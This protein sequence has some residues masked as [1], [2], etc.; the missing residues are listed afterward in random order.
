MPCYFLHLDSLDVLGFNQYNINTTVTF[1]RVSRSG[2]VLEIT[3]HTIDDVCPPCYGLLPE[4]ECCPQCEKLIH[5]A[6]AQGVQPAPENWSQCTSPVRPTFD[7]LSNDK[8]LLKGKVSVN[9]VRGNFHIAPG[10][11]VKATSVHTHDLMRRIPKFDLTH[12]IQRLR[13]GTKIPTVKYG[14]EGTKFRMRRSGPSRSQYLLFVTEVIYKRDGKTLA[15]SFEH[16]GL[17]RHIPIYGMMMMMPGIFFYYHFSPFTVIVNAATNSVVAFIA[18]TCGL[19]TGV[20]AVTA[21][22]DHICQPREDGT[23]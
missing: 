5:L 10:R 16:T 1:R 19:L 9:R 2:K 3:R 21:L 4:G 15:R 23:V 6:L 22:I 11:N 7:P 8:C 20:Y 14:L 18:S 17:V 13:F 12:N